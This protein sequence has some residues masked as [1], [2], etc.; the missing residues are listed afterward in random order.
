MDEGQIRVLV[1]EDNTPDVFLLREMLSGG[2]VDSFV[3]EVV[4]RLATGIS[5]L[6]EQP[7]DIVLLD[8]SLPDSHGL[9]TY[10]R[11]HEQVPDVP[12]VVMT[13]TRDRALAV[14]AV[15]RG[16]Q[17]YLVKGE[18]D[19][20]GL[21]RCLRYALERT[22]IRRRLKDYLWR[23]EASE[24]RLRRIIE[25]S[26]DGVVITDED[27]TVLYLNAAAE[28]LLARPAEDIVGT[29][30]G[31]SPSGDGTSEVKVVTEDGGIVVVE[32]ST[33][34]TTWDGRPAR[35]AA[36]RDITERHNAETLQS[37]LE[38][39]SLRVR[40]LKEVSRLRSLFTQ[41]V[42]HELRTPLTPLKT[43]VAMLMEGTLGEVTPQQARALQ[44]MER[45]I[46]RLARITTEALD[47]SSPL[48]TDLHPRHVALAATLRPTVELLQPKANVR[49]VRLEMGIGEDAGAFADPDSLCQVLALLLDASITHCPD[50]TRIR[51]S[52]TPVGESQV[53][54]R[55]DDDGRGRTAESMMRDGDFSLDDE[56]EAGHSGMLFG[57]AL[58]RS[59]VE[60]M[61]G[62][63][64]FESRMGEGTT[65]RFSLPTAGPSS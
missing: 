51:I 5:R 60:G 40:Q 21:R 50:G 37:R 2:G 10:D 27:R 4:D 55:I 59:L 48:S 25:Q 34:E 11:L 52:H 18:V 12:V 9:D 15:H 62:A 32:I 65:F 26:A 30:F 35:V 14:E 46:A 28:E 38:V 33:A 1:V 31:F 8:L 23:T 42:S 6:T 49:D 13:G 17:D 41:T 22:R 44:M 7:C 24:G 45:N 57:L 63:L 61:G 43:A 20:D 19:A 56:I 54:V 29:P 36:L 53:E 64:S 58:C 47:V 39:E 3:P 16:A